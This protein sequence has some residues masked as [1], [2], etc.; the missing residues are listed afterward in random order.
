M[1]PIISCFGD[2]T[3]TDYAFGIMGIIIV[4]FCSLLM[5]LLSAFISYSIISIFKK[6]LIPPKLK[7]IDKKEKVK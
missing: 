6:I 1:I 2:C 5:L 7:N 4:L 3:L